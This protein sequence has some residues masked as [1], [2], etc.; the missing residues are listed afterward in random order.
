MKFFRTSRFAVVPAIA[1]AGL[2]AFSIP[3]DAQQAPVDPAEIT[4]AQ[5]E[6]FAAAA[7]RVE[8]IGADWEPRIAEAENEDEALQ[9]REQA[10]AEMVEVV[11]EEGLSVEEYNTIYQVAQSDAEVRETI[12]ELMGDG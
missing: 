10:Q 7:L 12:Q 11:E 2:L 5:L 9:M 6:A 8:E 4:N 3:A 1:L